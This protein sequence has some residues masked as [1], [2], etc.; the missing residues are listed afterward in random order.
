MIAE[1]T[2]PATNLLP[3]W[4][5]K[6]RTALI[7]SGNNRAYALWVVREEAVASDL[8]RLLTQRPDLRKQ[9]EQIPAVIEGKLVTAA[10]ERAVDGWDEP[11]YQGGEHVG[12]KHKWSDGNLAKLLVAYCSRFNPKLEKDDGVT[13]ELVDAVVKKLREANG[14]G[15]PGDAG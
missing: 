10:W 13:P 12:D 1:R 7:T 2:T 15:Q 14:P 11:I 4:W 6:F 9:L 8:E 5:D 3:K